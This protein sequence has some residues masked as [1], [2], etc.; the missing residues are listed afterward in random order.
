[1]F[2]YHIYSYLET[3]GGQS[4]NLLLNVVHFQSAFKNVNNGRESTV[5]RSLDGAS[6][7]VKS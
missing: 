4:S 6:I 1:M 5:N 7:P 3:C 2:E